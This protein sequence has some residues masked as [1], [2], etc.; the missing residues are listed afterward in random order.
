MGDERVYFI[1]DGG[2]Q[3]GPH[4]EAE[5]M[6]M[7]GNGSISAAA[8]LWREGAPGW[9]PLPHQLRAT[10]PAAIPPQPIVV[11]PA[12]VMVPSAD[13]LEQLAQSLGPRQQTTTNVTVNFHHPRRPA[14][15][16]RSPFEVGFMIT[17]GIL[18]ALFAWSFF[19]G[20]LWGFLTS[21]ARH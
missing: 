17:M 20:C 7:V 9:M 13:P 3:Y 11:A 12:R 2:Q 14:K 4:S 5:I 16:E 6:E 18:C 21:A 8:L 15:R 10:A 1:S 19:N